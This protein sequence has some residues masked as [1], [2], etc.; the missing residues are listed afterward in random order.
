MVSGSPLLN[1]VSIG[2]KSRGTDLPGDDGCSFM[3]YSNAGL[4][5]GSSLG[6][7]DSTIMLST[8]STYTF[9]INLTPTGSPGYAITSSPTIIPLSTPFN[10]SGTFYTLPTDQPVNFNGTMVSLGAPLG[11]AQSQVSLRADTPVFIAPNNW[12][13]TAKSNQVIPSAS[14]GGSISS[15]FQ[16]SE[17]NNVSQCVTFPAGFVM[18]GSTNYATVMILDFKVTNRN[19]PSQKIQVG[20]QTVPYIGDTSNSNMMALMSSYVAQFESAQFAYTQMPTSLFVRWPFST[21]R[22]RIHA[23]AARRA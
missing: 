23:L 3:G 18:Q 14:L 22:L 20:Y 7:L 9:N 10:N 4:S 6:F 16:Y 1:R 11:H 17:T 12:N 13:G 21:T 2:L 5:D 8:R 19:T 15:N